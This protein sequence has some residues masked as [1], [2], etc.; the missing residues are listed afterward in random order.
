LILHAT[1][2]AQQRLIQLR[3]DPILA[4]EIYGQRKSQLPENKFFPARAASRRKIV[5]AEI[6]NEISGFLLPAQTESLPVTENI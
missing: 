6:P 2:Y 1:S 4:T 3:R 5:I